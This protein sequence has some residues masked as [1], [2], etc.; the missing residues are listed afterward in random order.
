MDIAEK[1]LI[2]TAVSDVDGVTILP[3]R[4]QNNRK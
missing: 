2:I 3:A 1:V 4:Q